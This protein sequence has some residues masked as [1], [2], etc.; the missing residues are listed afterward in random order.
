VDDAPGAAGFTLVE[1]VVSMF[2][3]AL[4]LAALVPLQLRSAQT[5][6]LAHE[7]QQGT[8]LTNAAL[9]RVR[10]AAADPARAEA[11]AGG[12]PAYPSP[13]SWTVPAGETLLVSGTPDASLAQQGPTTS[14]PA[15]T[16]RVYVT[17]RT[18]DPPDTL[19]ITG[20]T[21]WVSSNDGAAAHDAGRAQQVVVR[22]LL[23][24]RTP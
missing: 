1:V 17:T 11:I 19:W 24:A 23:H 9:E 21:D 8:A 15:F 6:G 7:R 18:G 14:V 4:C 16:T 22:S 3:I 13:G 12:G 5:V 20:V 10:D 2:M